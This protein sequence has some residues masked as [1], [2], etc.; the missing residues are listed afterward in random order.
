MLVVASLLSD[1][2]PN[3]RLSSVAVVG[4]YGNDRC[5]RNPAGVDVKQTFQISAVGAAVLEMALQSIARRRA[6]DVHVVY[7]ANLGNCSLI[8]DPREPFAEPPRA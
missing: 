4:E 8:S 3:K 7:V 5:L 6:R 1:E 2:M